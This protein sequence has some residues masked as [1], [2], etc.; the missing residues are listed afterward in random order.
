MIRTRF[1]AEVKIVGQC[2]THQPKYL[3]S[4]LALARCEMYF[5]NGMKVRHQFINFLKADD[6]WQ[7]IVE[8]YNAAPVVE[9][10]EAEL[11]KA[12]KEAE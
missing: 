7:E 2:G 5:E 8:A 1:G 6:G 4:E 9:L 12:F 10:T 11:E 3:S